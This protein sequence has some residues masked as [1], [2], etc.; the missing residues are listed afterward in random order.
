MAVKLRAMSSPGDLE[1]VYQVLR[2][3]RT[4]LS[5]QEFTS[6]YER[7]READGYAITGAFDGESCVGV[8]G[9]RAHR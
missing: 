1:R 3:L 7:A 5:F 6:T 4:E 2:E 9:C 8:M